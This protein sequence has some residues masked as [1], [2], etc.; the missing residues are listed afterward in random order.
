MKPSLQL[1]LGQHLAMTPQ[2]QQAIRLLQLSSLELQVELHQALESNPLLDL[3][4]AAE[5]AE[6]EGLEGSA[7]AEPPEGPATD[8]TAGP[9]SIPDELELDLRW[10]DLY[11]GGG[12]S[13]EEEFP[14]EARSSAPPSLHEQLLDQMRLA[15]FSPAEEVIA[16]AIIDAVDDA[17]YLA[18]PLEDIRQ[19]LGE[20][21]DPDDMEVV[22]RRIQSFHPPG[23]AARDL[24][25]CLLIQLEQMP[26]NTPWR[27]EARRAVAEQLDLLATHDYEQLARRLQLPAPAL[28]SVLA[29][30]RSLNPRPG[31]LID[32]VPTQ[33]VVPDVLVRKVN[34][35]WHVDLNPE[36]VPR[37]RINPYYVALMRR[38]GRG[39]DY[40]YIKNHLQ[41]A[42]WLIKSLNSRNQTLLKVARCIVERQQGFLDYGP[43]AMQPMVLH[44]IAEALGMHESTVSRVTMQK[45]MHTPRGTLELKYFFS[46]HVNTADGGTCSATALRAL[47]KKLISSEPPNAPLSDNRI[48]ELLGEQ[49]IQVARRTVAKY[50]EMM[51]IP[52]ARERRHLV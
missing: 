7:E 52:S 35:D 34:G 28:Q 20:E 45:Y 21:V 15:H 17:G 27:A 47:I 25:E 49:G 13:P 37:L 32:A 3:E 5:G 26:D 36:A 24:R 48:A 4:E 23:I 51:A 46:S 10:E 41:E 14:L 33:Y 11:E 43:E 2:L 50:R 38:A 8:E 31:N 40:R 44:D 1:R 22:L 42:R 29:L 16:L 18:T 39:D 6:S 12:G 9:D 19:G 30:I